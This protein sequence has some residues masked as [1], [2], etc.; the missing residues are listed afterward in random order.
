MS[1]MR[2]AHGVFTPL[3]LNF[4]SSFNSHGGLNWERRADLGQRYEVQRHKVTV[5]L[6]LSISATL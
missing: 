3:V 2:L 4:V 1:L 6:Q 5:F